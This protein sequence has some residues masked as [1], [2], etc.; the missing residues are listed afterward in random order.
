MNQIIGPGSIT[1][2]TKAYTKYPEEENCQM[3]H[4]GRDL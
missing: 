1:I 4:E 3:S 2:N